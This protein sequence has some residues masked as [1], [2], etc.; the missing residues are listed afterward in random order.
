MELA[1]LVRLFAGP[2]DLAVVLTDVDLGRGEE[3][4]KSA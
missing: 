1:D 3:L 2:L 4:R